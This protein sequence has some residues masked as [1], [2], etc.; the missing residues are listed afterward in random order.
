VALKGLQEKIWRWMLH[1]QQ[2]ADVIR[3]S[4]DLDTLIVKNVDLVTFIVTVI[5]CTAKVSVQEV[6]EAGQ[7]HYICSREVFGPLRLNIR[8]TASIT[9][10]VRPK[11]RLC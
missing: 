2:V 6:Q 5:N 10:Q 7:H 4:S 11:C 9:F 8:S 1:N 3:Q